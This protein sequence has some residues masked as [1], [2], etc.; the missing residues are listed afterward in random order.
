MRGR[1][2]STGRRAGAVLAAS[3]LF[4]LACFAPTSAHAQPSRALKQRAKAA[5]PAY[6]SYSGQRFSNTQS[7]SGVR[8]AH[9]SVCSIGSL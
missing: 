9:R 1:T 7:A 8:S 5:P 4:A 6:V 2:G 3:G